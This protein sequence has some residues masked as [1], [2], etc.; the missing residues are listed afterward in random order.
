MRLDRVAP[1]V[2]VVACV[3]LL[4]VLGAPYALISDSDA[5][6]TAYYAAGPVGAWGLA[7][8]ALVS[9]IVFLA[10]RRGRTDPALAAGIS[11][12]VGLVMLALAAWWAASVDSNLVFSFPPG[13]AWISNHRWAVVAVAALVPASAGAYARA[14][15]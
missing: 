12:A 7:F 1:L 11:L 4:L 8:L 9:V 14:V 10:G 13:A 2:G 6:V 3:A 5:G 15:V